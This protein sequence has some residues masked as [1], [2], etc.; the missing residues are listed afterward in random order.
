MTCTFPVLPES[1]TVSTELRSQ[2]THVEILSPVPLRQSSTIEHEVLS[3]L[4]SAAK[5]VERVI[6][7]QLQ[8]DADSGILDLPEDEDP[9]AEDAIVNVVSKLIRSFKTGGSEGAV[10]VEVERLLNAREEKTELVNSLLVIHDMDRL[11]DY[12]K[13]RRYIEKYLL[14]SAFKSELTPAE[15]L[16]FLKISQDEIKGIVSQ[17][18]TN[19]DPSKDVGELLNKADFVTKASEKELVEKFKMTSP[20]GREIL[21]KIGHKLAKA[22][23]G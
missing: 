13:L 11:P 1:L 19:G 2:L 21:R 12:L 10:K 22:A 20:Q 3:C 8:Q 15:A 17:V 5:L 14:R 9:R 4:Q 23:K 7:R 16:A 6:T 18:R